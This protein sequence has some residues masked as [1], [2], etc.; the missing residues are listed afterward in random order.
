MAFIEPMHRNKPN[1]TYLLT[2]KTWYSWRHM[3]I[4][5]KTNL[6]TSY[7]HRQEKTSKDTRSCH[8]WQ[9]GRS[10]NA[11]IKY[12]LRPHEPSSLH[13]HIN[14]FQISGTRPVTLGLNKRSRNSRLKCKCGTPTSKA[15]WGKRIRI[16][17]HG[18]HQVTQNRHKVSIS[19]GSQGRG[20]RQDKG[21]V[22]R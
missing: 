19:D 4:I 1:I 10:L 5:H 20:C 2:A 18:P 8:P 21:Q 15:V 6:G 22:G 3:Y 16:K 13:K 17:T 9:D 11:Q 12:N 7:T 14:M